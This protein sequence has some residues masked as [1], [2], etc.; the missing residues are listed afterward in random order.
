VRKIAFINEKGGSCKT[1]LTLN[2]GSYLA[3]E[4]GK[5]VLLVDLDP[6]GQLGKGLG[7]DVNSMEATVFEWTTDEALQGHEVICS[8]RIPGLDIIV[9]NKRLIDFPVMVADYDD[10]INKLQHRVEEITGYDYILFDAPPSLGLLTLNIMMATR[11]IIIPVS[12]TYFAMDGCA[13]IED[14]VD[15][16]KNNFGKDNLDITMIVPTLYRNTNL[17]KAI[18]EQLQSRFGAR[19]A[20]TVIRYDVKLDEAQSHGLTIWEYF[21]RSR[22]AQM[23]QD[24]AEEVIRHGKKRARIQPV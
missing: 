6:Q 20:R 4:K 1:T 18:L 12:M 19:V 3:R 7:F 22:G 8:S 13:E 5:K 23:M 16:V 14:T 24:L 9:S 15:V 21:P 10:R 11:E 2:I 17:A